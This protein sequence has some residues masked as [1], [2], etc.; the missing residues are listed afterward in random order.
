M[1]ELEKGA[2]RA[3]GMVEEMIYQANAKMEREGRSEQYV[4]AFWLNLRDVCSDFAS[5]GKLS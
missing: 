3:R 5:E 4:M 1:S 2:C